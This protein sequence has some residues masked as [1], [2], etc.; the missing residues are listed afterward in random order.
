MKMT[1][2]TPDSEIASQLRMIQQQQQD[3]EK[4]EQV[5]HSPWKLCFGVLEAL[6]R[7]CLRLRGEVAELRAV[8]QNTK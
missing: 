6:C 1:P 8:R 4:I 5:A 3:L 7:E 2:D